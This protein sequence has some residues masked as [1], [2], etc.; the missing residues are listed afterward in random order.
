MQI[1]PAKSVKKTKQN[2]NSIFQY[3]LF[4]MLMHGFEKIFIFRE[5]KIDGSA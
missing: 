5:K 1:I 4:I 3:I 2:L